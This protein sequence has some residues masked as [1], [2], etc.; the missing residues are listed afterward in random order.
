[1]RRRIRIR[2]RTRPAHQQKPLAPAPLHRAPQPEQP[3]QLGDARRGV[4]WHRSER[5]HR[6]RAV[7][8]SCC[9]SLERGVGRVEVEAAGRRPRCSQGVD[10]G[11]LDARLLPGKE[12]PSEGSPYRRG[13]CSCFRGGASGEVGVRRSRNR[14]R[15]SG[16]KPRE[17]FSFPIS[18]LDLHL[19]LLPLLLLVPLLLSVF[20]P[21]PG[22]GGRR[23]RGRARS[24]P[25]RQRPFVL[26]G[27]CGER[28][29]GSAG[30]ELGLEEARRRGG[31]AVVLPQEG[32][33]R[34][35]V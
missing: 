15:R 31:A 20:L 29:R 12:P 10:P 34:S 32:E 5:V 7:S 21:A 9:E 18:S 16:E 11:P 3:R 23:G 25:A 19:E 4:G 33:R 6:P 24:D 13:S 30:V 22:R 35:R 1:M 27:D 8:G 17:L 14:R 28:G 2:N 26:Q